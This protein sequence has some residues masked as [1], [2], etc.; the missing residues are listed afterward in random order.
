MHLPLII[1]IV[2]AL[3]LLLLAIKM[4]PDI[5]RYMKIRAM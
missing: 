5:L 1:G 3:L 4:L 2:F